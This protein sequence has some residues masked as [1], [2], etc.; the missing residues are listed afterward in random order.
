MPWRRRPT[1]GGVTGMG[2]AGVGLSLRSSWQLP[3][4][5]AG[6]SMPFTHGLHCFSARG[7]WCRV[8]EGCGGRRVGLGVPGRLVSRSGVSGRG[9]WRLPWPSPVS[10]C[11]AADGAC[12]MPVS[13]DH[14]ERLGGPPHELHTKSTPS[15]AAGI[16]VLPLGRPGPQAACI[17]TR[18]SAAEREV[19]HSFTQCRVGRCVGADVARPGWH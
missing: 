4:A 12:G 13:R 15:S 19:R 2:V 5:D 16:A 1:P 10:G 14:L 9:R 8:A 3:N 11:A 18:G 6:V 17:T 7:W